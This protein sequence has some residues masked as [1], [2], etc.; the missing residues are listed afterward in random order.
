MALS[1]KENGMLNSMS[2][3]VEESL[4]GQMPRDMM[5]SG[6]M[7]RRLGMADS[8]R[9]QP[10]LSMRAFGRRTRSTVQVWRYTRM[11][12]VDMKGTSMRA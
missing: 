8:S 11:K 1:T 9:L 3:T 7:T 5:A 12:I 4:S 10:R 2:K 6:R